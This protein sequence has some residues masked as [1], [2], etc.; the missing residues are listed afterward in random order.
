MSSLL[1][2]SSNMAFDVIEGD[3]DDVVAVRRSGVRAAVVVHP[4]KAVF[5]ELVIGEVFKHGLHPIIAP[6]RAFVG[7]STCLYV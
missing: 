7:M 6:T 3:A 1:A 5:G 4:R 2:P